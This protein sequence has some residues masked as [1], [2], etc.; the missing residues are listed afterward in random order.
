MRQA[1][2]IRYLT[3]VMLVLFLAGCSGTY[4]YLPGRTSPSPSSPPAAEG[5]PAPAAGTEAAPAAGQ[6]AP[7]PVVEVPPPQPDLAQQV[8]NLEIRMQQ[9]ERRLADL[10]ARRPAP[11]APAV[12]PQ[13]RPAALPA[14]KAVYPAP[15]PAPSPAAAATP[16]AEKLY[17]EGY[18][19][20]QAKKYAA[21]RSKFSQYLKEPAKGA[22]VQEARYYLADSF[23]QEGKF[24]E[25][26]VEFHKVVSQ[27]PKSILAP[28]ALLRQ[29]LAY[30]KLQQPDSYRNA[31]RKLTQAYPQS[32]EAK[33]AE[34]WLK[35]GPKVEVPP[36]PPAKA[37]KP[38]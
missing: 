6:P 16:A 30:Q 3:V 32:P 35:Q 34:K 13:E 9:L 5:Q 33:E 15:A 31:L 37:A 7:A 11:S 22:K 21:A 2:G 26:A 18:R 20:Y 27:Y 24:K 12:R 38:E 28:A 8:Q 14:S 17:T 25:A 29:A 36:K 23:Y 4:A 10:E 1:R 19:L